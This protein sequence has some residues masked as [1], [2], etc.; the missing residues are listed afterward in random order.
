VPMRI[1]SSSQVENCNG[2]A[3]VSPPFYVR[4][5]NDHDTPACEVYSSAPMLP[6]LSDSDF[7]H[8]STLQMRRTSVRSF[9]ILNFDTEV[10]DDA[11]LEVS[12]INSI[13]QTPSCASYDTN[14]CLSPPDV[15]R[16]RSNLPVYLECPKVMSGSIIMPSF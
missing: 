14:C 11:D 10:R 1:S 7:S 3:T 15:V 9:P 13:L 5:M 8:E 16:R 4:Y 12:S 2:C 6:H